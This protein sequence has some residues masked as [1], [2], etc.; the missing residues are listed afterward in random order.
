MEWKLRHMENTSY[1]E[2]KNKVWI[3]IVHSLWDHQYFPGWSLDFHSLKREISQLSPKTSFHWTE[4]NSSQTVVAHLKQ[5]SHYGATVPWNLSDSIPIACRTVPKH[6]SLASEPTHHQAFLSH[7]PLSPTAN[8]QA[9]PH[10]CLFSEHVRTCLT[11]WGK[12]PS[13]I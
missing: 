4:G 10:F 11:C 13:L 12:A 6:V 8:A 2:G 7:C 9:T 3:W 1:C 5:W